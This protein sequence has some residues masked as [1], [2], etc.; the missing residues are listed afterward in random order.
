MSKK[1]TVVFGMKHTDNTLSG[2][3]NIPQALCYDNLLL[4]LQGRPR[5][6]TLIGLQCLWPPGFE[7]PIEKF[8]D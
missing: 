2:K 4:G 5:R 6:Q 7:D 8:V 3:L 1:N